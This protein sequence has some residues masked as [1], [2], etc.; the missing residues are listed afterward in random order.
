[1][2]SIVRRVELLETKPLLR[3]VP[4]APIPLDHPADVLALIEEQ[5]NV[6]RSDA[7]AD[8]TERARTLGFL[9]SLALRAMESRDITARLEAVERVLKLREKAVEVNGKRK[10]W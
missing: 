4:A 7:S 2:N 8:P 5:V 6:V 3:V 9:A 1:M 10:K